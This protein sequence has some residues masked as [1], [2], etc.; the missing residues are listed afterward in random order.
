MDTSHQRHLT[1]GEYAAATQLTAKALRLYE[2]H[3]LITPSSVDRTT[4]YRYYQLE[5]VATGRLVRALREMNLSLAQIG[6]VLGASH[7]L[8]PALLRDFLRDAEQ[9]LARE[10]AAYQS[11]LLM[12]RSKVAGTSAPVEE[13]EALQERVALFTLVTKRTSF[14]EHASQMLST[15]VS[16]LRSH[17]TRTQSDCA[18]SLLEPLSDDEARIELAVPIDSDSNLSN[19]TTRLVSARRYASVAASPSA[20][21]DGFTSCIDALFDWFDR[22]G[23]EAVGFPEVVLRTGTDDL[24]VA[25][26]WAFKADENP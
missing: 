7:G 26:R 24:G 13:Y 5:Q 15:Q 8:Q 20:L 4:G 1:I 22:K 2:E 16:V 17:R 3:G 10:R 9:R 14:I 25:V 6:Q 19:V 11:A 12:L 18:F 21:V 23:V